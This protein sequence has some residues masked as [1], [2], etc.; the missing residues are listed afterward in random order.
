ME[1]PSK[2]RLEIMLTWTPGK[3]F[4]KKYTSIECQTSQEEGMALLSAAWIRNLFVMFRDNFL[5]TYP[6]WSLIKI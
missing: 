4:V 1:M 6:T 5:N 2:A 3:I